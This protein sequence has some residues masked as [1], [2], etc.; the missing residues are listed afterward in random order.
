MIEARAFFDKE[1]LTQAQE[2]YAYVDDPDVQS[3]VIEDSGH[4][5]LVARF[6]V[7]DMR[8]A[9]C[10]N[11]VERAF[12]TTDGVDRCNVNFVEQRAEV[13]FDPE[14]VTLSELFRRV[15]DMGYRPE[16]DSLASDGSRE[17]YRAIVKRLG[18]A[19]IGAMQV[20]M[21]A[22]A[23]YAGAFQGMEAFYER[24]LRWSSLVICTP[25]VLYSAQ[26]FFRS[27]LYSLR[28]MMRFSTLTAIGMDVPIALAIATAYLA[29][30]SATLTDTG[31]VYYDSVAMFTF[32]LLTARFLESNA[33]R[34]LSLQARHR[35]LLPPVVT[36]LTDSGAQEVPLRHVAI[37]ELI[38]VRPGAVVPVDG[39]ILEGESEIDQSLLSGES[40][41][42]VRGVGARVFAGTTNRAQPICVRVDSL[43]DQSRLGRIAA[44]SRRALADK[45]RVVAL[46]DTAAR[47][48]VLGVLLLAAVTLAAWLWVDPARALWITLA[49]LVVSCPCALSVATPAA[50]TAATGALASNHFVIT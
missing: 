26:P 38:L 23:L 22:I 27:A 3:L 48:F 45:P 19:G 2:D 40:T 30:V 37:G 29:S 42:L 14:R 4:G 39:T 50:L 33:R 9:G 17:E 28:T 16:I 49:V 34:R 12:R 25:I 6:G 5:E 11:T 35:S 31:E 43:G 21:F 20:M 24:L 13:V 1:A 44:L 15:A 10:A 32:F 7:F 41:P 47:Y 8:C 18:L 46:A 36:R